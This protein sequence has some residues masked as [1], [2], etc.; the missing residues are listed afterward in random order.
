MFLMILEIDLAEPGVLAS[1]TDDP[2][3]EAGV[4]LGVDGRRFLM[5][6]VKMPFWFAFFILEIFF[7]ISSIRGRTSLIISTVSG[8]KFKELKETAGIPWQS[9]ATE[10]KIMIAIRP[11]S[12]I[13]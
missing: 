7:S 6:V 3:V 8:G 2:G 10:K 11:T 12:I 13:C 9:H 1:K 5:G 4:E